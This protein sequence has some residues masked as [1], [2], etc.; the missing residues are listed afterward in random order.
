MY[1]DV[2]SRYTRVLLRFTACIKTIT[3]SSPIGFR[4]RS[5][6]D[7]LR[8][9]YK[10]G[11]VV[12]TVH[13]KGA[14]KLGALVAKPHVRKDESTCYALLATVAQEALSLSLIRRHLSIN[15]TSLVQLRY[16]VICKCVLHI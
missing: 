15:A 8:G 10:V 4:L 13:K 7:Y 2:R 16:D 1:T 14:D 3:P 12:V 9:A 5:C 11:N 6:Q